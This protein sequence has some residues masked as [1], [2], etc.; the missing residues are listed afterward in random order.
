MQKKAKEDF[1]VSEICILKLLWKENR[2]LTAAE[3]IDKLPELNL[4]LT[5]I[6]VILNG[7]IKKGFVS[8]DGMERYGKRSSKTYK[9]ILTP[10]EFATLQ[11]TR[12]LPEAPRHDRMLGIVSSM[13]KYSGI[14]METISALEEY[15]HQKRKELEDNDCE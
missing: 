8:L 3:M 7:M 4:V 15:L 14:D 5:S 13:T 1:T 10:E 9:S 2:P 12:L 6:Y 11:I